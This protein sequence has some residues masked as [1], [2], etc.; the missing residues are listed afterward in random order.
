MADGKN[1]FNCARCPAY[2]C[3]YPNIYLTKADLRRLARHF[4]VSEEKARKKFTK[5]GHE[6]GKRVLRHQADEYYGSVCR[7][8]DVETRN[9]T[10]YK[11]RPRICKDFP[12][13]RRCGYYDFLAFE[14]RAQDDPEYVATTNNF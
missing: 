5:K 6:N 10:V 2:C 12:G 13:T 3:S 9:C 7:F 8:L 1:K 14:R 4:D 11:A